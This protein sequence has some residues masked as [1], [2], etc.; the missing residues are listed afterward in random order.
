M[1]CFLIQRFT[2]RSPVIIDK[3]LNKKQHE[4]KVK[5][6]PSNI[7]WSNLTPR[8]LSNSLHHGLV[9]HQRESDITASVETVWDQI[10]RNKN[11]KKSHY[12]IERVKN[13]LPAFAFNLIDLDNNEILKDQNL[14][15]RI[16]YPKTWQKTWRCPIKS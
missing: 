10:C 11:C 8:T 4:A 13:S 16:S 1:W 14:P 6:Y 3:K 7:I 2:I 9:I 12:D 15:K 5:E